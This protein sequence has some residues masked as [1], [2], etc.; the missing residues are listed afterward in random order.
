MS[1]LLSGFSIKVGRILGNYGV[2][3]WDMLYRIYLSYTS[4]ENMFQRFLERNGL[5]LVIIASLV[6]DGILIWILWW[7]VTR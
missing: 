3:N 5:A 4:N 7:W 6:I 1:Y 2:C